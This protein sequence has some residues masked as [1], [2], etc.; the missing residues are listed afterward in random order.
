MASSFRPAT[1]AALLKCLTGYADPAGVVRSLE[2]VVVSYDPVGTSKTIREMARATAR[3]V[4]RVAKD[5]DRL[6]QTLAAVDGLA[7]LELAFHYLE[8][9]RATRTPKTT[10][11]TFQSLSQALV[12]LRTAARKAIPR[13]KRGRPRDDLRTNLCEWV[14]VVLAGAPASRARMV[15]ERSGDVG[16]W[17]LDAL[18]GVLP[19]V[20]EAM[21]APPH[22]RDYPPLL[23]RAEAGLIDT[24]TGERV[25]RLDRAMEQARAEPADSAE[26]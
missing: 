7:G 26:P 2:G 13:L 25:R 8:A 4:H 1:R 21:G 5:T 23:K 20:L 10:G 12:A 9:T 17:R 18:R 19:L 6:L 24:L 14:G 22:R 11:G 3:H 16:A 15:R